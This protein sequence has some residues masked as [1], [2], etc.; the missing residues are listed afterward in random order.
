MP[1]QPKTRDFWDKLQILS[2]F[3]STVVLAGGA[4]VFTKWYEARQS[5]TA[6][7]ERRLDAEN[8]NRTEMHQRRLAE[9]DAAIRLVPSLASKDPQ[10]RAV[11]ENILAIVRQQ[12][13]LATA[14]QSTSPTGPVQKNAPAKSGVVEHVLES[15]RPSL[16]RSTSATFLPESRL[17]LLAALSLALKKDA[18][19]SARTAATRRV[20]EFAL[21][22]TAPVAEKEKA[23]VAIA[24]I[25]A[26]AS[27][28]AAA[29]RLASDVLARIRSVSYDRIQATIDS[30]T[31]TRPIQE[32]VLHHSALPDIASYRG[33][34]SI[35]A[36]AKFQAEELRWN[37]L[38]W[39]FAVAPDGTVW[40]GTPLDTAAFHLGNT[41]LHKVTVS[42]L[43]I[44][45]GDK[46]LPTAEQQRST[47]RLLSV[48]LR[49]LQL[50]PEQN[51]RA[52]HG[53]HSDYRPEKS[54]PGRK[55][56]RDVV[57]DWLRNQDTAPVPRGAPAE[58]SSQG[59]A[60]RSR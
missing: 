58:I 59:D 16:P 43:M 53:F 21:S 28:P 23:A 60:H 37:R 5:Q 24:Q 13:S 7:E 40:V 51:F 17:D 47:A 19:D 44:L 35:F 1:D 12:D 48:L 27:A 55:I 25:A 8:R 33:A 30:M 36:L 29:R 42:V 22:S 9:V 6:L 20:T 38:S 18:P 34:A 50:T 39:H 4:L 45:N 2:S 10:Q 41:A 52:G 54:C 15:L 46:E 49:R 56:T 14:R 26:D 11:A 31:L 57:L 32:V 3:F